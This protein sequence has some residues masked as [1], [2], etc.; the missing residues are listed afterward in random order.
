MKSLHLFRK[1]RHHAEDGQA[2]TFSEADLAATVAAYDPA[3]HEAPLVIGH[4]QTDAPAYGWVQSISADRNGLQAAVHQ[5][6][7][8]FAEM[9]NS[10]AR[11]KISAAFYAPDA[12]NNPVKGVYYL[13]H[14][15]FLGAQPP[16]V[17]GLRSVAFAENEEGIVEFSE[18][19]LAQGAQVESE[20]WRNLRE[21]LIE[22]HGTETAD[23]VVPVWALDSLQRSA[24]DAAGEAASHDAAIEAVKDALNDEE[25]TPA[26]EFAEGTPEFELAQRNARLKAELA[27][28]KV[29]Q[30]AVSRQ[31]AH[32]ANVAFAE[33][34][35]ARGMPPVHVDAV[36][37]ALD[38]TA[39]PGPAFAESGTPPAAQALR[40]LFEALAGSR[41][42]SF[43]EQATRAR[44]AV[45]ES[46]PLLVDALA[47]C[48][49]A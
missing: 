38:A 20:L 21:W 35:V 37:A 28:L 22:Q 33:K 31:A 17:K 30:Q 12:P 45:P 4:P 48:Q 27:R 16:A 7:P 25:D 18:S 23:K 13:K 29:Q 40:N 49:S 14:V 39:S 47:R 41:G 10:G 19:D 5:V 42:V 6:N 36:V 32:T 43:A 26:V 2:I 8:A 34:L 24:R 9:V 46:N 44:G 11:K 15:G 1:G 3:L